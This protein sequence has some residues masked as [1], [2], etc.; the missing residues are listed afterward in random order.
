MK[1]FN[2]AE[3]DDSV[4]WGNFQSKDTEDAL[5]QAI[6]QE[7]AARHQKLVFREKLKPYE[8]LVVTSW[9]PDVFKIPVLHYIKVDYTY[10]GIPVGTP[11]AETLWQAIKFYVKRFEHARKLEGRYGRLVTKLK[12]QARKEKFSDL[13]N[14]VPAETIPSSQVPRRIQYDGP[15]YFNNPYW[16][17]DDVVN[18]YAGP[19]GHYQFFTDPE[20]NT[21][22][23][24]DRAL[25]KNGLDGMT[26][27]YG[28]TIKPGKWP[29]NY[30]VA[31][32][33]NGRL[34]WKHTNGNIVYIDGKRISITTLTNA[35][36]PNDI[37]R[38]SAVLSLL[39]QP[40]PQSQVSTNT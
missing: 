38:Q 12:K 36:T 29:N 24:L 10:W 35:G 13:K 37:K 31:F 2:I 7:F 14:K 5:G 1:L 40:K 4:N 15:S 39:K 17:K 11:N 6:K 30:F 27:M 28:C 21:L 19:V 26:K 22:V 3:N 18:R 16:I 20:R 25:T 23:E 32:G 9:K 33:A 34:I 8:N